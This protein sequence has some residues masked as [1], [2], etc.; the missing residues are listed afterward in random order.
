MKKIVALL[1]SGVML[2]SLVLCGCTPKETDEKDP[3]GSVEST[4]EAVSE[5]PEFWLN[6]ENL[7]KAQEYCASVDPKGDAG[8][9]VFIDGIRGNGSTIVND[10]LVFFNY[11]SLDGDSLGINVNR[12][13]GEVTFSIDMM[14][15]DDG[16]AAE[17]SFY[18]GEFEEFFDKV[19]ADPESIELSNKSALN[20]YKEAIKSDFPIIFS[21][22]IAFSDV[23]LSEAGLG[24]KDLGIDLGDKYR[25]ID[26]KQE[27]SKEVVVTDEHTFENGI[28]TDCGITWVEYYCGLVYKFAKPIVN[29]GD[30]S[31][32]G[33]K[34]PSMLSPADELTYS[35]NSGCNA[36]MCYHHVET[37]NDAGI[38]KDDYCNIYIT[39]YGSTE[40]EIHYLYRQQKFSTGG[41]CYTYYVIIQAKPG[42]L[43]KVFES[44]E[45]LKNHLKDC[46][47]AINPEGQN[48]E[49]VYVV[50]EFAKEKVGPLMET[51]GLTFLTKDEIIDRFWNLRSTFFTSLDNGMIWM[52][53]SL[54]DFGFNWQ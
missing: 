15:R 13:T 51:D 47:L 48:I 50:N 3:A 21:R 20:F 10:D 8:V 38:K 4:T 37:D 6:G 36:R 24:L 17:A 44:K 9:P 43:D 49:T 29:Q 53:T 16:Y 23:A 42:E 19:C 32:S 18:L 7:R 40:I 52:K 28:C 26:P 31:I 1:L 54:K 46:D 45:S 25:A 27:T 41:K 5:A 22:M 39:H 35:E 30:I 14:Y 33:Q 34:S 12:D 11:S 2:S